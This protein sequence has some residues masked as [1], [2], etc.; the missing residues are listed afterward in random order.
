MLATLPLITGQ[1]EPN[2]RHFPAVEPDEKGSSICL[3][4]MCPCK[5][6]GFK[7]DMAVA[8]VVLSIVCLVKGG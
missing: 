7:P 6:P 1:N 3:L 2:M 4:G 8:G 5:S